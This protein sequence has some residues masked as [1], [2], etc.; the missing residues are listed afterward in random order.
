MLNCIGAWQEPLIGFCSY[1]VC[2]RF[3]FNQSIN[4]FI[5]K[6]QLR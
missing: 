5:L 3:F 4:Q 2:E 1:E 6:R